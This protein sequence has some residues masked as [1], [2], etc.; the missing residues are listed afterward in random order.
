MPIMFINS[1]RVQV[2]IITSNST[3]TTIH[4]KKNPVDQIKDTDYNQ[5][6]LV[7]GLFVIIVAAII[8]IMIWLTSRK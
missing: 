5:M 8:I 7:I 3:T 6:A 4:A 1:G 2:P